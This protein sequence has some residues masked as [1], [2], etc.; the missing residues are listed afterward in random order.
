MK[1]SIYYASGD[2]R[3]ESVP[4][5]V[6]QQPSDAI[7]RITHACICGSN[8]WFYRGEEKWQPGWRTGHEWMGIVE[9][10]GSE[11]HTLKPGDRVLAPF[12]LSDGTCEFCHQGIQT[13]CPMT[14]EIGIACPGGTVGYVGVP[15][16]SGHHFNLSRLFRQNITLR[17]DCEGG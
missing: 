14:T 12:A 6:I 7:V 13:S 4:D 8:L 16:G 15:H 3:V 2:V 5:P 10:V 9:A 1:A 17:R 11:V